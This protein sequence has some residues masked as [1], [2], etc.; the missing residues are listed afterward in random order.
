MKQLRKLL[1]PLSFIYGS[2]VAVR[3]FLYTSGIRK[4]FIVP[5]KS[6]VVGNLSVG[7]TGKTPHVAYLLN[8]LSAEKLNI[9]VISRGYGRKTKGF[10]EVKETATAL[11]VG[12]EPLL[13][14]KRFPSANVAV[15]ESRIHGIEQTL[16]KNNPQVFL[17]DDAFQHLKIKAEVN[18]LLTT[19]SEPFFKD[20]V[21]P[22]GNLREFS[23][24]KKRADF[25][26]VTKCPE[27]LSEKSKKE[28]CKKLN[29]KN[30]N[31]FF[32]RI[33]YGPLTPFKSA[34]KAA[35]DKILLVTGIADPAPLEKHL[36]HS[37]QVLSV[38]FADHHNFEQKDLEEIH[39]KFDTFAPYGNG[40]IVT[41]EKDFVRLSQPEFRER[42]QSY[43]WYY[44]PIDVVINE[45]ELFKT[46]ILNYV[47]TI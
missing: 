10:S 46:K 24:G 1:L 32:S 17:F 6:I 18:I 25:V 12:D 43:P 15:S 39:K 36:T 28:F 11:N 34:S 5:R 16:L 33:T 9:Q 27:N 37:G 23:C 42:L 40:I 26:I 4:R 44:Q 38:R 2:I 19:F 30:K 35:F 29:L 22:A 31:I 7:G 45:E 21:L 20:F 14:K 3:N 47:R 13:L 8:L 41:T